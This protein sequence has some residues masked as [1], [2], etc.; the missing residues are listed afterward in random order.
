MPYIQSIE[1]LANFYLWCIKIMIEQDMTDIDSSIIHDMQSNTD[2]LRQFAHYLVAHQ[3]PALHRSILLLSL[4]AINYQGQ[5]HIQL[6]MILDYIFTATNL[7]DNKMGQKISCQDEELSRGLRGKY[8]RILVGDF[9]YSR[10][11][12]LMAKLADVSVV[13]H[14]SDAI[15]QYIEG[16]SLQICQ[17]GD[18]QTSEQMHLQRLK[19]KSCLYFKSIAQL[20]ADLGNC[21]EAQ[22]QALS[23][24]S[25]HIG[26]AAQII[27]ETISCLR[28]NKDDQ[29]KQP[30]LPFIVIRGLDQ[31]SPA[32]SQ[33]IQD[34]ISKQSLEPAVVTQFCIETD[35]VEVTLARIALEIKLGTEV[36]DVL[37]ESIY[38]LGLRDLA[39]RLLEQ[40]DQDLTDL[41]H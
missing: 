21:C 40:F 7:H 30:N 1:N 35:A 10:A 9:F 24:Y 27:E 19:Q 32:L 34:G 17:A 36:L 5:A 23:D 16:Q 39:T 12:N 25:F 22:R 6:G 4:K 11:F 18:P 2:Y 20:A 33:L 14:L 8:S 38:C 26:I 31:A 29:D 3:K 15:N 37:P 41:G 28:C 13:T